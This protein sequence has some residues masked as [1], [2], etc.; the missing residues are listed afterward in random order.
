MSHNGTHTFSENDRNTVYVCCN[1]IIALSNL[2]DIIGHHVPQFASKVLRRLVL[3]DEGLLGIVAGVAISKL[4]AGLEGHWSCGRF[5]GNSCVEGEFTV[6]SRTNF[7]RMAA[8]MGKCRLHNIGRDLE[9][10]TSLIGHKIPEDVQRT[11]TNLNN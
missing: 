6:E 11:T 7:Q 9:S 10:R 2:A 1:N 8:T 3:P 4:G 5:L